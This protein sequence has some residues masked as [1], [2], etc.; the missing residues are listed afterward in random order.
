MPTLQ[1]RQR[2]DLFFAG[3]TT[4]VEG[5][6]ESAATGL[7]AGLNA[8]RLIAGEPPVVPPPTTTL[9]ALLRYI[10]DSERKAFQPMNVNF[11]LLPPLSGPLRKKAKKEML[12]RRALADMEEWVRNIEGTEASV[13]RNSDR[14]SLAAVAR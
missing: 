7:L 13:P 9:G 6:I 14:D 1:W 3:Q 10:T 11:G 8:A 12:A 4:G 5:Y 2:S